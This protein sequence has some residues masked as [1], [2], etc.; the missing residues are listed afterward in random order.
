MMA[1]LFLVWTLAFGLVFR[2]S[3]RPAVIVGLVGILLTAAMF[4]YH[5]SDRIRLDL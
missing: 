4:R 2:D 3:R 5:L 1:C